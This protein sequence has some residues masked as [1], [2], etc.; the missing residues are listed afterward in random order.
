[1]DCA[2]HSIR[3]P[4]PPPHCTLL[5]TS[6]STGVLFFHVALNC[7]GVSLDSLCSPPQGP[8]ITR[9]GPR[10]IKGQYRGL[11]NLPHLLRNPMSCSSPPSI[12]LTFEPDSV[13]LLFIMQGGHPC[14][15]VFHHNS[16][17]K[18]ILAYADGRIPG[19]GRSCCKVISLELENSKA[20][21]SNPTHA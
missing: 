9:G 13:Y 4:R 2:D 11:L 15:G 18:G 20:R 8:W 16:D 19:L 12:S 10:E 3:L 1:V 5:R 14:A 17:N 6:H 7:E 21:I